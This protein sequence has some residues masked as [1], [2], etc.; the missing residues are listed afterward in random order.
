MRRVIV[1]VMGAVFLMSVMAGSAGA[2]VDRY[3]VTRTDYTVTYSIGGTDF[4]QTFTI[5]I[6]PCDG[7]FSGAGDQPVWG[8]T[9]T[10]GTIDGTTISYTT[11]YV[12]LGLPYTVTVVDAVY[13]PATGDFSGTWSDTRG[14]AGNAVEGV[15]GSSTSPYKNH[16]AYVQASDNKTEAAQSCIGMPVVSG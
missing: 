16:G 14:H 4:P 11:D 12:V 13:D 3:Q 2:D 8:S 5:D 10:E 1:I 9:W 7:T 15:A 6:S